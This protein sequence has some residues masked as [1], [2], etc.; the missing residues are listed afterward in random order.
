MKFHGKKKELSNFQFALIL[1]LPVF[2]FL[3]VIIIYPLGF[4]LW[5]SFHRI[6]FFGGYRAMFVGLGNYAT[7]LNSPAFWHSLRVSLRFT[8]ESV[9]LTL[10]IGLGIALT[11]ARAFP[12]K[13]L[14]R[15][16]AIL[17]WA[18][19]RYAAGIM[20]KY[21]WRG[22]MG[23]PTA[24]AHVFGI[25]TRVDLLSEHTVIEALAI[26]NAWNLAPLVAFFL[27]ANIETIPSRLYDMA[28]V[29]HL[30]PFRK[31]FYVT[32][33]YLRYTL[34]VFTAIVAVLSLKVFDYIFVQTGGGPGVASA[35]LTYEVYKESF[36]NL[37]LGY[38]AAMSFYLLGVILAVAFTL[39]GIWGRREV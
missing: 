39:Y 15:S 25:E 26:G 17:P 10:L 34:F 29:D 28:E 14:I 19:S 11:L 6:I 12:G 5:A 4:A 13:G 7:V 8:G 32:L 30:G 16:L 24:I 36:R 1:T 3:I 31:F 2:I 33:P 37:N 21:L 22:R 23:F 38:G 20:F 18:V 35:T 9:A 27:L